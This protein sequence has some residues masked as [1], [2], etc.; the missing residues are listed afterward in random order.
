MNKKLLSLLLALVMVFSTVSV[1]AAE[2]APKAEETTEATEEVKEAEEVAEPAELPDY[3][4]FLQDN[5]YVE[6]DKHGDLMLDKELTRAQFTTLLARLDGK[7]DVAKAMQQLGGRFTDVNE[8]H[9]AKGYISYAA[10][11]GWV[12]GY[13]E[14]TFQPEKSISY[15]EICATLVR[16]LGEDT[17]GFTYPVDYI[18]KAYD[19]KLMKDLPAIENYHQAATRQN[20][21]HMLYNTISTMD[22]GRYNVY[23][24]VVLENSRTSTLKADEI[25]AEVVSVIQEANNVDNRGKAKI[26][27]QIKFNLTKKSGDKT[28]V[29]GD[30]ENLLGKVIKATVDENGNLVKVDVEK[31]YD[32]IYGELN[33]ATRKQIVVD[34]TAYDVRVDERYYDFKDRA[35]ADDRMFRTYLTGKNS[36]VSNYNYRAFADAIADK[37]IAPNFVRATIKDGMVM[38]IDAYAMKDIA[39]VA[40]VKRDGKDVYY[41]NDERNGAVDR[42]TPAPIVI[43]Y[44]AEK[45]FYNMDK[46]DISKDDVIHMMD[47]VTLVREDAKLESKLVKTYVDRNGEWLTLEGK[48][49]DENYWLSSVKGG[50]EKYLASVYAYDDDHYRRLDNRGLIN[51][52]VGNNVKV[53]LDVA[54]NVQL[55]A[56]AEKFTDTVGLVKSYNSNYPSFYAP[57]GEKAYDL[58]VVRGTSFYVNNK[59]DNTGALYA[60]RDFRLFDLVYTVAGEEGKADLIALFVP[61]E[62]REQNGWLNNV[63][64]AKFQD[65]LGRYV[66]IGGIDYRYD[67]DTKVFVVNQDKNGRPYNVSMTMTDVFNFNKDNEDLRAFVINEKELRE[68]VEDELEIDR[69][70]LYGNREDLAKIIIFTDANEKDVDLLSLQYGRINR[71]DNY[72]NKVRIQIDRNEYEEYLID[73]RSDV[74]FKKANIGDVVAFR[75][76]KDAKDK[77]ARFLEILEVSDQGRYVLNS[78]GQYGEIIIQNESGS[79]RY[80]LSR[81]TK[82][83]GD[84]D[85]YAYV[86]ATGN[87]ADVIV[88]GPAPKVK[89]VELDL[90]QKNT[91]K[92]FENAVDAAAKAA[93]D[94]KTPDE[95]NK[96]IV[97][98]RDLYDKE[99]AKD[100][101]LVR[102][103]ATKEAELKALEEEFK[104][105]VE[106]RIVE[107]FLSES[108]AFVNGLGEI[109]GQKAG[110]DVTIGTISFDK[111]AKVATLKVDDSIKTLKVTD[112]KDVKGTGLIADSV[113]F[114]K[115]HQVEKV[116]VGEIGPV[117]IDKT[118]AIKTLFISEVGNL[119]EKGVEL[120]T[121]TV[122]DLVNLN[123]TITV[124]VLVKGVEEPIAL[125]LALN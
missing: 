55:V 116:Y 22:F 10:G 17:T 106:E 108:A 20:M 14:G 67:D 30:S 61:F 46:A 121:K 32:Y 4:K 56:T 60:A 7:D 101:E 51:D 99:I 52:M 47:G 24:M 89:P 21:F 19:L 86:Y 120:S 41:Y 72:S 114:A 31:T 112:L 45:G 37:K 107:E 35:D 38:F 118:D 83:F 15:A 94:G 78:V 81:Y 3:V 85:R 70:G 66:T 28:L 5:G 1:F 59:W 125:K 53:L 62:G 18:A 42:M 122:Q 79:H 29:L 103:A 87:E 73:E 63:E 69:Y 124:K 84:Y 48:D 33:E 119:F 8:A 43:G 57:N 44:T 104:K 111:D 13:P 102:A 74:N 91:L 9:W 40:D 27:T 64:D 97:N 34:G 36:A 2:E 11:R 95:V 50:A 49:N 113:Q 58:D 110:A 109:K 12:N 68:F 6:G 16:Y 54:E 88:Y 96:L 65:R 98:A 115:E 25:K 23:S 77:T 80:Y 76:V 71:I 39:P 90:L 26:G 117:D 82:E 100:A 93:A 105:A 92:R 75:E 123:A